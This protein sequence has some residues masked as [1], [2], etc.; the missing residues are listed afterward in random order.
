[1]EKVRLPQPISAGLMLSYQCN[2]EC[3]YCMYARSPRWKEWISEEDLNL[4]LRKLADK[5]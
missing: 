4:L 5:I 2:A 1:M 3:R